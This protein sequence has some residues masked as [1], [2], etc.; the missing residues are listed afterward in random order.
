MERPHDELRRLLEAPLNASDT[1]DTVPLYSEIP[2]AV[3]VPPDL[4]T[5]QNFCNDAVYAPNGTVCCDESTGLWIPAPV[6]REGRETSSLSANC[7]Q[8]TG[9]TGG[10]GAGSGVINTRRRRTINAQ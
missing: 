4:N 6:I 1:N 9:G 5:L 8:N 7:P 10:V 2:G 3:P